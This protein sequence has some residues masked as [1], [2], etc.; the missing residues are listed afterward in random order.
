MARERDPNRDKAYQLW[1]KHN[2]EITNREIANKLDINEKKVAVWKSRDKWDST[3]TSDN[4]VQRNK[5]KK[6]NV[7]QQKQSKTKNVVQQITTKEE[8]KEPIIESDNLTDK[9]K[10]FCIYYLKYFNAT[11][12]Y[13]KAYGCSYTTANTE[14]SKHLV[15]PRIKAEIDRIKA[16]R[17]RA[18]HLDVEAIIQKYMDIAFADI[19]DFVE[20]G[21]KE[22]DEM[23]KDGEPILDDNGDVV[24][25]S[26]SFVGLKNANEVDGTII[27]EVKKGK[28][29]VSVKLADKMK[30]LEML[31]KFAAALPENALR[32]LQEEKLK[33]ETELT[34]EKVNLLKGQ[35]KDTSMMDALLDVMKE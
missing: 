33:A 25:N 7:V 34:Q 5:V 21:Q 13:Q 2:G 19:T 28:D 15:K 27:S 1:K 16:E 12:A 26:Y 6:N 20:F 22:Y 35:T 8:Y 29:G 24:K 14:G 9:Q 10:L 4:V 31:T 18:V 32:L 30:A 11:K 17:A 3:T 23:D